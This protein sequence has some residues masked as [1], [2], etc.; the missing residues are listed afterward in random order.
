MVA[1]SEKTDAPYTSSLPQ[2]NYPPQ[3]QPQTQP[4]MQQGGY[5]EPTANMQ[6]PAYPTS[7][8]QGSAGDYYNQSQSQPQQTQ[9]PPYHAE[10]QSHPMEQQPVS[11]VTNH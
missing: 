1:P 10:M 4:Q 2:G 9:Y 7:G 6:Q 3:G 11:P 5:H 8:P